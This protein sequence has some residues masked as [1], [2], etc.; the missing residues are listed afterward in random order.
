MITSFDI[1]G[2]VAFNSVCV[3][4]S[5][6]VVIPADQLDEMRSVREQCV[7]VAVAAAS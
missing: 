4:W 2:A 6:G 7:L 1:L 5:S 3:F